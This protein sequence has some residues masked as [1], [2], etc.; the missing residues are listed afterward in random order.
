M[1]LSGFLAFLFFIV[2]FLFYSL[3]QVFHCI[4]V[5]SWFPTTPP[6][7]VLLV[8]AFYGGSHKQ[9]ID[10][11]NKNIEGCVVYTLPAKK[12]HWRARTSALYFMQN[13]P[14]NP[15]YRLE[16]PVLFVLLLMCSV[17][18]MEGTPWFYCFWVI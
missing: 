13:I 16:K 10:I 1:L 15:S 5:L 9:L 4:I 3:S 17:C 11:L 8:E 12:W 6:M 2:L 18:S 14:E 7:S